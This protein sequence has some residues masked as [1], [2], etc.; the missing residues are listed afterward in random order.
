MKI[1]SKHKDY[2]DS[3]LSHGAQDGLVFER[4]MEN[5]ELPIELKK[6]T[7]AL[8]LL[9][10]SLYTTMKSLSATYTVDR[11][12]KMYPIM[13]VFCGKIYPGVKV[14]HDSVDYMQ[15]VKPE[16]GCFFD[17]KSLGAFLSKNNFEI[18]DIKEERKYRWST[19]FT[20]KTNKKI[21]DFF[22]YSGS[23]QFENELLTNKIVTA[24]L[25]SYLNSEGNHFTI[26]LPLKEVDF[27]RK[28]D[29]WQA[30]Q[31]LSMYIGGVLAPES[32]PMIKTDD[33]YKVIGHGFDE[34]SF[35]KLPTKKHV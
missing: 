22:E 10:K 31:E 35:R 15:P 11:K 30:Y 18:S 13:V 4:K 23:A 6:T 33:K 5:I 3:A 24:V 27:Y 19:L 7:T 1:Y 34:M 8:E 12:F 14:H 20:E 2:Y 32:K 16:P 29:A 21:V 28:F 25:N 17:M 26:N 9:G